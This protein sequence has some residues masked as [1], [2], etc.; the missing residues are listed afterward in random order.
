MKYHLLLSSLVASLVCSTLYADINNQPKYA[1][2]QLLAQQL[3]NTEKELP[4]AVKQRLNEHAK[5]QQNILVELQSKIANT[6]DDGSFKSQLLQK[7]KVASQKKTNQEINFLNLR[8]NDALYMIDN[9]Q[10]SANKTL[11]LLQDM[12][13]LAVKAANGTNG[14]DD[15]QNLNQQFQG[16][17]QVMAFVQTVDL[18]NGEKKISGG[19]I[20]IQIGD[21]KDESSTLI[22]KIPAF[23]AV[24][25]GLNNSSIDSQSN[26]M[27]TIAQLHE[28]ITMVNE[29]L[30]STPYIPD[31]EAM[32]M[33]I[34]S[35]L[36][37]DYELYCSTLDLIIQSVNGVY[38][39]QDRELM[40]TFFDFLKSSLTKTQTYV[41]LSGP[42]KL[43]AGNIHI[44]IGHEGT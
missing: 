36:T 40:D 4:A 1:S 43:G 22:I 27:T 44:Q 11:S 10:I 38:S 17:K 24:A 8:L 2:A 29:V 30:V 32:L 34:P 35:V 13:E 15:L 41:S 25:L 23:D 9:I 18:L 5:Y 28:A 12:N 31:A 39:N 33:S 21:D 14:Q 6:N 3:F 37:Q 20:T 7:I 42:K 26:A 19:D 16:Y